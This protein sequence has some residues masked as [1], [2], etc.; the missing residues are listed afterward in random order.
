[1]GNHTVQLEHDVLAGSSSS[2]GSAE[3]KQVM[4]LLPSGQGA[5]AARDKQSGNII[6]GV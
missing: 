3:P 4:A 6:G 5:Q 1:M 2:G